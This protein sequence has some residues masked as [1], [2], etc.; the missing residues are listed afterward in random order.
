MESAAL[1]LV[2]ATLN[3]V[4]MALDAPSAR[5]VVFGVHIGGTLMKS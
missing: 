1:N 5:A 2:N 4:T 3:W